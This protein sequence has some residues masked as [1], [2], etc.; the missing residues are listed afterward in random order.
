MQRQLETVGVNQP[1]VVVL[2]T[3]EREGQLLYILN[4]FGM[5]RESSTHSVETF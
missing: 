3:V 4:N 2:N 1:L 5:L